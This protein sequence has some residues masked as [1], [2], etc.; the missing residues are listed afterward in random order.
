MPPPNINTG[1]GTFVWFFFRSLAL[2][3]P[4]VECVRRCVCRIQYDGRAPHCV[5]WLLYQCCT[6][7]VYI[8]VN[9]MCLCCVVVLW[10]QSFY[11][12]TIEERARRLVVHAWCRRVERMA[13]KQ[14]DELGLQQY[15]VYKQQVQTAAVGWAST[16]VSFYRTHAIWFTWSLICSLMVRQSDQSTPERDP[17]WMHQHPAASSSSVWV[18]VPLLSCILV[19]VWY[20]HAIRG[21]TREWT[22]ESTLCTSKRKRIANII[23]DGLGESRP[24]NST[25]NNWNEYRVQLTSPWRVFSVHHVYLLPPQAVG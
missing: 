25:R 5:L 7:F 19:A 10:P 9:S 22:D 21:T 8:Y 3:Y 12:S 14:K 4:Y 16:A 24:E 17:R 1:C 2:P 23:V 11:L 6:R 15:V 20:G 18:L 13:N